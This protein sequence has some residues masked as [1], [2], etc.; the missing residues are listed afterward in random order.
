MQILAPPYDENAQIETRNNASV[1]LRVSYGNVDVLLPGDV[2]AKAEKNLV[3]KY[4][5]QLESEVVKIPHHG[6]ST[7]STPSF[8]QAVSGSDG[9]SYAVVS[10][11]REDQY[12]MP[13]EIVLSRW[14]T[15]GTCMHSTA[16]NGAVWMRTDGKGVWPVSWR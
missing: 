1:V 13:H 8:V 14:K 11:G 7:S 15:H 2:E 10:V 16:E 3:R 5:D 12:G 6:S 4:G 9:G